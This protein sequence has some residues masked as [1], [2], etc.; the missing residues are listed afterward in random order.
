MW[1]DTETMPLSSLTQTEKRPKFILLPYK[2]NSNEGK[3]RKRRVTFWGHQV[4]IYL[5]L[6]LHQ[7]NILKLYD[8]LKKNGLLC[9]MMLL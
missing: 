1:C 7:I 9:E 8:E 5:Y 3:I 4:S 6:F 2:E